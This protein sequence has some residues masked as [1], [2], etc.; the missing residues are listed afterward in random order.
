MVVV[1]TGCGGGASIAPS[2]SPTP[3]PAP[4]AT[5]TPTPAA[6]PTPV[7]APAPT[8]A[9]CPFGNYKSAVAAEINAIRSRPQIC[10]G[11]AYPAVGGLGWNGQLESAADKHATDMAVNN[12]FAHPGSDGSRIGARA[13]SAGYAYSKVGENIAAGQTSAAQVS[14]DWLASASHCANMMTTSFVDIGASCKHN[15]SST[16]Q[17]YWTLVMGNR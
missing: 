14:A 3:A 4:S 17:Y 1:L 10:G 6:T 5:P 12:F 11:V 8:A 7:P 16:Y 15:P 9:E 13:S 2:P